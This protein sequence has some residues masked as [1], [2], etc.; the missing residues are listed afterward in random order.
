MSDCLF[1]QLIK[2][3]KLNLIY[4]DNQVV[5]FPDIEPKAKTHI[6]IVPKKHIVSVA[7][8]QPEDESVLGHLFLVAQKLAK[9]QGIT[10][11]GFRTVVNTGPDADQTVF[12]VHMHLLGGQSLGEMG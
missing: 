10:E 3:Q 7:E 1:C 2:Q 4:E 9:E 6:L 8:A 12:H 11:S 5:A